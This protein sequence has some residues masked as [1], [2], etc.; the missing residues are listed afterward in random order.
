MK[1]KL[2]HFSGF[3]G[4]L[5]ALLSAC[6]D[7]Y[8][9]VSENLQIYNK[10]NS[11]VFIDYGNVKNGESYY[12]Y[13]KNGAHYLD[14]VPAF[15]WSHYSYKDSLYNNLWMSKEQFHTLVAE[16]KIYKIENKDTLYVDKKYY[17]EKEDWQV[18]LF[19]SYNFARNDNSL[20]ITD[21]M[22]NQ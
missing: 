16:I 13:L 21:E 15:Y 22:F 6:D 9:K 10:T 4:L 5:A 19:R 2:I 8:P 20:T 18:E 14:T 7:Q 1:N 3:L 17:D 12:H 11:A